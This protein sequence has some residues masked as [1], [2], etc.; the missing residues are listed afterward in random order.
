MSWWYRSRLIFSHFF[1]GRT[2]TLKAC[3][4]KC[5]LIYVGLYVYIHTYTYKGDGEQDFR[6]LW[7]PRNK[8]HKNHPRIPQNSPKRSKFEK[9]SV[10]ERKF[11]RDVQFNVCVCMNIEWYIVTYI[12]K[13]S[14]RSDCRDLIH[15]INLWEVKNWHHMSYPKFYRFC[16]LKIFPSHRWFLNEI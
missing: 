8:Q 12:Y 4:W 14:N 10:H 11:Q 5:L 16:V 6:E 13:E 9:I 2:R 15:F 7:P 1:A 3:V